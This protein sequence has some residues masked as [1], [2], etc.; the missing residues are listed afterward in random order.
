MGAFNFIW[1]LHQ[2]DQIEAMEKRIEDLEEKTQILYEWVQYLKDRPDAMTEQREHIGYT[3]REEGFYKLYA[4][5]KGSVVTQAFIM[6]KYCS[7]P[8]Y[9]CSGP[10]SDAVCFE[11]HDKDPDSR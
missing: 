1:D 4:P 7:Q 3:E 5:V 6:C 11:C 10:R 8:I 2:S 9:H